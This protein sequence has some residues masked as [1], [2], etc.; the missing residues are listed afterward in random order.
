VAEVV[1][2]LVGHPA[3]HRAVADHRDHAPVGIPERGRET[4]RVAEDR[5]RVAVL[6]PIVLGLGTGG[7]AGQPAGLPQAVEALCAAGEDLVDV[8]LVAGVPQDHVVRR[9]EHAVQRERQLDRSEVRPQMPAA[10]RHRVDDERP[11][12]GGQRRQLVRAEVPQVLRLGDLLQHGIP[13]L[14]PIAPT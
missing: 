10:A 14:R 4:V 9:V 5:R 8:G 7:V 12:V 1:E 11:H 2:R 3:G 13:L 6:D